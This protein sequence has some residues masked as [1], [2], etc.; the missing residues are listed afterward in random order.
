MLVK[1]GRYQIPYMPKGIYA[2]LR[3]ANNLREEWLKKMWAIKNKV[4]RWLDTYFPEFPDVFSKWEGKAAV[5][6]L[7]KIGLPDRIASMTAVEMVA[8]WREEVKRGVG[9]KKAQKLIEV[10][11]SSVGSE[12]A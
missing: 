6:T 11:S 12:K 4:Q 2:E 7:E 3:K 8:V 5:M 10:A 1:D 9:V